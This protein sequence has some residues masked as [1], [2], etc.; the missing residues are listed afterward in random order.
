VT[1]LHAQTQAA[2]AAIR[3]AYIEPHSDTD[4]E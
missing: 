3:R 2:A 1:T 4:T